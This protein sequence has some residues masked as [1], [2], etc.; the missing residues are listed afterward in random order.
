MR[1]ISLSVNNVGQPSARFCQSWFRSRGGLA[2]HRSN[3]DLVPLNYFVMSLLPLAGEHDHV[4]ASERH[5]R[6]GCV[7]LFRYSLPVKF[8]LW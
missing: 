2:V 3:W 5:D 6:T 4:T 1:S 7:C 8:R